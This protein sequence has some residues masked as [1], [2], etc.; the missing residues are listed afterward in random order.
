MVFLLL[1]IMIFMFFW[2]MEFFFGEIILLKFWGKFIIGWIIR[3]MKM[4][5]IMFG[6]KFIERMII[7]LLFFC[8]RYDRMGLLLRV[9]LFMSWL[10]R[11]LKFLIWWMRGSWERIWFFLD[12]FLWMVNI[13]WIMKL[14]F[15]KLIMRIIL[16]LL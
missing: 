16:Y 11:V 9:L 10:M 14:E 13:F 12:I 15:F 2:E 8:G 6:F 1:N 7:F 5:I 4:C 3:K